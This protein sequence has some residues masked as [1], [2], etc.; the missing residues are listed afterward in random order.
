MVTATECR[1]GALISI[2][3]LGGV[4][5]TYL[6]DLLTT[7]LA[8]Q[9]PLV[10]E[11]FSARHDSTTDLGRAIVRS[12]YQAANDDPF[13]RSGHPGAETLA[14]L[15]VKM[16]DFE[17]CRDALAAGRLV[18]EGRSVHS[19]AVYQSLI[20]HE[21][22]DAAHDQAR[23]LLMLARQWRP[24]PDLTILVDDDVDVAIG[25]A[26]RRDNRSCTP[27]QR[28][29][30]QRAARLYRRLA[31]DDPGAMTVLDRRQLTTEEVITAMSG[32]IASAPREWLTEPWRATIPHP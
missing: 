31:T 2:E 27:E 9:G 14:L 30:H 1:R 26:E 23:A 18:L 7:V 16:F 6:T 32:L 19:T 17:R 5:K 3:G 12:L 20:L 13:L 4:G 25:R 29:I 21:D 28:R 24:L 15:A 10:L 8:D 11:E 22:D